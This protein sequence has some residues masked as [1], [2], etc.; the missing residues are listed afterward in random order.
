MLRILMDP[1]CPFGL[2]PHWTTPSVDSTLFTRI[3]RRKEYGL[4]VWQGEAD[5]EK[6][7]LATEPNM[8]L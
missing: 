6:R 8:V 7:D 3:L 1:I 2:K 4:P 5:P